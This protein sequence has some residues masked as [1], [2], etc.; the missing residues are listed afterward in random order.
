MLAAVALQGAVH[1]TT[2]RQMIRH[3][4][5]HMISQMIRQM[6]RQ[7]KGVDGSTTVDTRDGRRNCGQN[8]YRF[9]KLIFRFLC[10][11][12]VASCAVSSCLTMSSDG[13]GGL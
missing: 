13:G 2:I 7:M 5:R 1:L 12:D 8:Q 10:S 6:I 9:A 4:I 11:S 3:M